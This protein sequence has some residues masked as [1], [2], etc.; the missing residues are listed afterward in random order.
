MGFL[1]GFLVK[2]G[3][4]S[5]DPAYF[6]GIKNYM[7]DPF[8]LAWV[9]WHYTDGLRRCFGGVLNFVDFG[10]HL[11]SVRELLRTLF[12]PWKGI[13]WRPAT[14]AFF[15]AEQLEAAWSN[16]I[17]RILGAIVRSILIII[18]LA[19]TIWIGFWMGLLLLLWLLAPIVIVSMLVLGLRLFLT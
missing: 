17:S 4:N 18:G 10:L 1:L 11:F 5:G 19:V 12:A 2:P 8:I 6:Y 3:F 16:L 7:Q 15:S 14:Q 13:E 9:R